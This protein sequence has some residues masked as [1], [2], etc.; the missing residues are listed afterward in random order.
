[1]PVKS[2]A[3]LRYLFAAQKRSEIPAGTAEKFVAETSKRK[4]KALPERVKVP[5]VVKLR[6][7]KKAQ[8]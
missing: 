8:G 7:A 1:V 3:Q 6:R 2:L 4:L 5:G